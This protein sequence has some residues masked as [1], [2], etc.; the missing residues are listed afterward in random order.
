MLSDMTK[1]HCTDMLKGWKI[2][3]D[4][5]GKPNIV[6]EVFKMKRVRHKGHIQERQGSRR[7]CCQ[8]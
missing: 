7:M 3:P 1:G 6:T 2:I 4:Y 8:F 5:L